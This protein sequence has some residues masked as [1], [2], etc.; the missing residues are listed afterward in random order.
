M[1]GFHVQP[2]GRL[3]GE[4]TVPGGKSTSRPVVVLTDRR[5]KL[6][7]FR[8]K[9]GGCL[10]NEA[11]ASGGKSTLYRAVVLTAIADGI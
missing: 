9:P 1:T 8:A 11:A 10:Q 3:Q 7:S 4:A 6:T 2:G 5:R